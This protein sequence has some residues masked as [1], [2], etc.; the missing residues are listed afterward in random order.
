MGKMKK[1]EE[2]PVILCADRFF[3]SREAMMILE[4]AGKVV[5]ADCRN[6][7]DLIRKVC[8]NKPKVIVSEYFRITSQVMDASPNLR[9]IVVWGVGYDHVDVEAASERGIYVVNTAGSN[10]ESVAEHVFGLILCLSRKIHRL[11]DFVR[12]GRW[13]TREESGL[14]PGLVAQD[15]YG[16][17]IGIIGLGAVGSR[18]A[19]IA[20]GFNMRILAYDPYISP[21]TARERG[22]ELVSLEK[23]L[24]ESDFITLHV[25]LN[26]ETERMISV[27]ELSLMKPTAY[28]IN[29]S[30]GRVID[31]EALIKALEEKKIAGA[32]LD[33]F[34]EEPVSLD[35]PLLKFDNV[36]V[37]PH[38]AG[39]SIEA[40]EK[41]SLMVAE[42]VVRILNGE[43]PKNL[44]NRLQLIEK[45]YLTD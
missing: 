38:C 37:T 16:K 20:R 12:T 13:V 19:R 39:N 6:E 41:T 8:E 1:Y 11:D 21:E 42:E 26:K 35:N 23:L 29:T 31:E 22:A 30:R 18:V 4:N 17:T 32:G 14:P 45:G 34:I 25:P 24:R 27:K 40:L 15:I 2:L 44:V 7:D 36:I 3:M 5:W 43:V 9:G 33:V 28:L 10:A